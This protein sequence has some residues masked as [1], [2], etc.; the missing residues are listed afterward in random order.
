MGVDISA[1]KL[2]KYIKREMTND[3]YLKLEEEL[4]GNIVH[5]SCDD[6]SM[7]HLS[8]FNEGYYE[9]EDWGDDNDPHIGIPYSSYNDFRNQVCY[10]AN[11]VQDSC[12]WMRP[13]EYKGKP[14]VEMVNFTDCNGSFDYEIAKKLLKDFNDFYVKAK[15]EL[16]D[17]D[18]SL[19][20]T[21]MKILQKC[22]DYEG[23]V[24]YY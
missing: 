14:F 13:N 19:Y 16:S 3:E 11:G 12:I 10:M 17:W 15:E 2:G 7:N 1:I 21:Y 4:D 22:I 8:K 24:R 9:V 18:F 5:V 20:E 6:F 23:I